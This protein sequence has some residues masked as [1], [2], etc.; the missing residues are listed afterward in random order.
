M[1]KIALEAIFKMM[2]F[3]ASGMEVIISFDNICYFVLDSCY[4][5]VVDSS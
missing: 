4:S 2:Q 5:L 3:I 1:F